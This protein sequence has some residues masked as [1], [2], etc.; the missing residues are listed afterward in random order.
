MSFTYPV[1]PET[2]ITWSNP[3][4]EEVFIS[5]IDCFS[6]F[7]SN[8]K[9]SDIINLLNKYKIFRT[10]YPE[11]FH[12]DFL[13]NQSESTDCEFI[14]VSVTI[15]PSGELYILDRSINHIYHILMSFPDNVLVV[16]CPVPWDPIQMITSV[17]AKINPVANSE[18]ALRSC[19]EQCQIYRISCIEKLWF[20]SL[21]NFHNINFN[22]KFS[23]RSNTSN[24]SD[25]N[26]L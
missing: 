1:N 19:G 23:N 5:E 12:W 20:Q 3:N 8:Y 11:H 17:F 18:D 14:L 24:Y 2:L 26:N 10:K 4:V 9:N 7:N 13:V 16:I 6:S 15:S 25:F 21:N 22:I